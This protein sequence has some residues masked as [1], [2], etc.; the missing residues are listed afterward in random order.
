MPSQ[1]RRMLRQQGQDLHGDFLPCC[2]TGCRPSG[3]SG[4][5]GGGPSYLATLSWSSWPS[6]CSSN[7]LG[8]RCEAG[9]RGS[10]CWP[11]RGGAGAPRCG[12]RRRPRPPQL[13][14]APPG[15]HGRPATR[16]GPDGP[17]GADGVLGPV[18]ADGAAAG[19]DLPRTDARNGVS[20]LLAGLR[21]RRAEAI[22]VRLD[23]TCDTAG[24]H[25]DPQRP[26]RHAPPGA[27]H[28]D[29]PGLPGKRYYVFDGGCITFG[30]T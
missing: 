11:A 4:G 26:R 3:S 29:D 10:R 19:L 27:G 12:A 7:L 17:V 1:L 6:S 30:S 8:H 21:P 13:P 25:R 2:P 15:D 5:P 9:A 16:R 24:R 28:Q 14:R 18:P 20:P 23:A 22:E